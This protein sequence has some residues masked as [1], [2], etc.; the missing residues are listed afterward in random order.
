MVYLAWA[1]QATN[2]SRCKSSW[3]T[4]LGHCRR[5]TSVAVSLRGIDKAKSIT[6]TKSMEYAVPISQK[7]QITLP[8][9]LRDSVGITLQNLVLISQEGNYLRV[10]KTFDLLDLAGT[11]KTPKGK[12]KD[13]MKP[14]E[15]METHYER[16]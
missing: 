4:P 5:L 3:Y 13:I 15:L 2:I 9:K 1:L 7:G 16:F 8:K 14:R 12:S 6:Y 10:S 11:V